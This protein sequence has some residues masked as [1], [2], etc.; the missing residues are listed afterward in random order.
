MQR[1]NNLKKE[2]RVYLRKKEKIMLNMLLRNGRTFNTSISRKLKISSQVTGRIRRK[3]ERKGI[4]RG[5]SIELDNHFL[6]IRAFVLA[7]IN[8]EGDHEEKLMTKNLLDLYRVLGNSTTHIA[9]YGF[10]SLKESDDY[11]RSLIE[12]SG[13]IKIINTYSFPIEGLIKHSSKNLFYD[14]LREFDKSG[15]YRDYPKKKGR[16]WKKLIASEKS[17]LQ[18]L[19][20]N[21]NMSCK[22]IS[23]NLSN[24]DLTSTGVYMIKNRLENQGVIRG[25]NVNLDYEK[26]G[27]SIF[28]FIFL[29]PKSESLRQEES[30]I[31]RCHGSPYVIS[32]FRLNEE[33][34]MFCGFKNLDDLEN[35][36]NNILRN[37]FSDFVKIK[38]VFIISP[39]GIIKESFDNLYLGLLEDKNKSI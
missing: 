20:K 6:G 16:R 13:N 2:G 12:H 3:L 39:K 18:S 37:K 15:T 36:C 19:V 24:M 5:Y 17:V 14:A 22:N 32:C 11:F 31:K 29:S 30:L 28:A 21:S 10:T 33:A 27:V 26:L 25:Y 7:R 38:H 8:I 4:I 34:A 1:K 35:Y 9:I 23:Y